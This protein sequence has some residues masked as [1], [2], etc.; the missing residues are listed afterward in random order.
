MNNN[1]P[2]VNIHTTFLNT[3]FLEISLQGTL[4]GTQNFLNHTKHLNETFCSM[5]LGYCTIVNIA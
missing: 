3:Y 5:L 4:G 1:I 2:S